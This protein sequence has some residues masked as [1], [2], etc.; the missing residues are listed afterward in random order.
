M[1]SFV[2][3]IWAERSAAYLVVVRFSVR[4]LDAVLDDAV[5]MAVF[6]RRLT[7]LPSSSVEV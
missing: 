4:G 7:L 6:L 2:S 1:A 5:T 3:N